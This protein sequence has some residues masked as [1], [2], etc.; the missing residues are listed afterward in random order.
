M[1]ISKKREGTA[2]TKLWL[3]ELPAS[4]YV[5]SLGAKEWAWHNFNIWGGFLPEHN[6]FIHDKCWGYFLSVH[7]KLFKSYYQPQKHYRKVLPKKP[8]LLVGHS[9]KSIAGGPCCKLLIK[10]NSDVLSAQ[11]RRHIVLSKLIL[12]SGCPQ[13]LFSKLFHRVKSTF[14]TKPFVR[15]YRPPIPGGTENS[16]NS[17]RRFTLL[18][19]N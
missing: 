6:E 2:P 15:K 5:A 3:I 10:P 19:E 16:R 1:C 8:E 17:L 11:K 9:F 7:N 13:T 14:A 18:K 12:S 4:P